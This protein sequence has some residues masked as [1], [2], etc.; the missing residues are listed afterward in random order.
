MFCFCSDDHVA[1][2]TCDLQLAIC[3]DSSG[4]PSSLVC[5]FPSAKKPDIAGASELAVGVKERQGQPTFSLAG[6]GFHERRSRETYRDFE[7]KVHREKDIGL[8]IHDGDGLTLLVNAVKEGPV[9]AWNK[10]LSAWPGMVSSN[11]GQPERIVC[12]GDR[13]IEVG[14]VSGSSEQMLVNISSST[15]VVMKI[16][17]LLEYHV[18][19]YKSQTNRL[20][21][22]IDDIEAECILVRGVTDGL[23]REWNG[24]NSFTRP[25]L[26]V[27]LGDSIVEV[28]EVCGSSSAM[29]EVIHKDFHLNIT[30]RRGAAWDECNASV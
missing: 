13:I 26:E 28:N 7:V 11:G 27:R 3:S 1:A 12:R 25:D 17:R 9:R 14:G 18:Q 22:C 4:W 20:G 21:L 23:I 24:M 2:K 29:H 16:R 15:I 5:S 8:D 30:F 10:H 19:V 6:V